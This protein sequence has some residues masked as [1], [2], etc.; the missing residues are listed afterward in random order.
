[1]SS[2]L[3]DVTDHTI[4]TLSGLVSEARERLEEFPLPGR[5][6]RRRWPS[7]R[8]A[9]AVALLLIVAVVAEERQRRARSARAP[10]RVTSVDSGERPA[11]A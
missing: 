11:A 8:L 4:H 9:V 7:P 5:N 2:Q 1:M 3:R 10:H 6:R